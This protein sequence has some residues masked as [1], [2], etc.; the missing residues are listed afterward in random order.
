MKN[1]ASEKSNRGFTLAELLIVVAIIAVLVAIAIP[2]FSAQLERSKQAVDLTTM[3]S[4]YAAA[5]TEWMTSGSSTETVYYYN[6]SS[7]QDAK[8]GITGYGQSSTN[9]KNFAVDVPFKATGVPNKNGNANFLTVEVSETGEVSMSWGQAYGAAY[10]SF[11]ASDMASKTTALTS[12]TAEKRVK[13][14]K[15][16]MSAIGAHFLGMTKDEI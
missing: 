14:D 11:A 12:E 7:V 1:F 6:G 9:A 16:A 10:N 13:A 3:R 15:D 2:V 5:L 8:T 4:A